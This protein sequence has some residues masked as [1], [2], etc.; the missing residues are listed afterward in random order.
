MDEDGMASSNA[1]VDLYDDM[2]LAFGIRLEEEGREGLY[3]DH[4]FFRM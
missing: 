3:T 1:A 4:F 2:V